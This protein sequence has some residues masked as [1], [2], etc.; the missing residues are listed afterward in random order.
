M[1]TLDRNWCNPYMQPRKKIMCNICILHRDL[2]QK[3][4]NMVY[5]WPA[6]PFCF[7]HSLTWSPVKQE[8][9]HFQVQNAILWALKTAK[10]VNIA[11]KN[12]GW[13]HWIWGLERVVE[14]VAKSWKSIFLK[15]PCS[16]AR[17]I[18]NQ[19]SQTHLPVHN[20]IFWALEIAKNAKKL[21]I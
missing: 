14:E 9:V 7:I 8:K 6:E 11:S 5:F 16:D 19:T 12:T 21:L 20:T 18:T 10:N 2:E 13:K 15:E 17:S 4:Q 1:G 3:L